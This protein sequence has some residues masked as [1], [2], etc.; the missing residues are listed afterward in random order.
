M[1]HRGSIEFIKTNVAMIRSRPPSTN[2]K[3]HFK[4]IQSES[5][6]TTVIIYMENKV[7]KDKLQKIIDRINSIKR[8][9]VP[10]S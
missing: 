2:L 5:K 10:E 7:P 6:T 1:A 4:K 3:I 9:I 8:L